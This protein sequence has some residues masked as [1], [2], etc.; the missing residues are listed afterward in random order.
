N[1]ILIEN[2]DSTRNAV[3]EH[4]A[5]MGIAWDGDFDRCFLFDEKGQFIE[6]YYI[7]GLLAQAFLIKQ[8]GEKIVHDPRLV[9]NTF[10]IVDE[11]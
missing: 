11:Y 5:D 7:V 8:S 9:W 10:D 3:L 1:P 4:K 2:R 6:G